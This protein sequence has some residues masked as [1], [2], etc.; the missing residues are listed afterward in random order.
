MQVSQVVIR[1]APP[2][3]AD[4]AA[5]S[6]LNPGLVLAFGSVDALRG[7]AAAL[8]QAFP[9]AHRLGCSTAGEI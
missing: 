3:V 7:G 1:N 5:L 4:F 6:A 8:A 2:T 9:G